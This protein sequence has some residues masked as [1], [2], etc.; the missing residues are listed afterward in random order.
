MN[1]QDADL[2]DVAQVRD[3]LSERVRT[4]GIQNRI[5]SRV[6]GP[7]PKV[8]VVDRGRGSAP[9]L[10][11]AASATRTTDFLSGRIHLKERR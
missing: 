10:G 11:P 9:V 4:L 5:V 8:V 1:S 3:E 6:R 7:A 2:G